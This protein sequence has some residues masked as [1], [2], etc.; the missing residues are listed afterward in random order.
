MNFE[1]E[2]EIPQTNITGS[3]IIST[4]GIILATTFRNLTDEEIKLQKEAYKIENVV[5]KNDTISIPQNNEIFVKRCPQDYW[6]T[7]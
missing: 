1:I 5:L 7:I 3:D 4:F 2:F 6:S